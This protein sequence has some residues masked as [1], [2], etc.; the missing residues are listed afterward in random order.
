METGIYIIISPSA[1][2]YIGQTSDFN[3]RLRTYKIIGCRS[4]KKIYYSLLKYGFDAHY[5]SMIEKC[6]EDKL[7]ERERFWQD[8]YQVL[9]EYGMNLKLT[10]TDTKSGRHSIETRKNISESRKG[11][12]NGQLGLKRSKET[13]ERISK[14]RKGKGRKQSDETKKKISEANQGKKYPPE[15]GNRISESKMGHSVSD[16]TRRKISEANK[17]KIHSDMHKAKISESMKGKTLSDTHKTN[18]SEALKGKKR[19]P[20]SEEHK[21]KIQT[22]MI[23]YKSI[24]K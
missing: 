6:S 19:R 13:C 15:F 23:K 12:P 24:N 9:G 5:I 4:Q 17:G 1:K 18:I 16:E 21:R 2:V 22:A 20:L 11:K 3:K 7:N 8:E 10:T 14:A